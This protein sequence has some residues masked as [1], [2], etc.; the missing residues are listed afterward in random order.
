MHP[1]DHS[2]H[3]IDLGVELATTQLPSQTPLTSYND[4]SEE[5][6]EQQIVNE[7]GHQ[8]YQQVFL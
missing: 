2:G 7:N 1:G 6:N 3:V 5:M 8:F 4:E